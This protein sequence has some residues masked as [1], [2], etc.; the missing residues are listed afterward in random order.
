MLS[1]RTEQENQMNAYNFAVV[2][3]TGLV[4]RTFLKVLEEYKIPVKNLRLFA[5]PESKG[6]K[7]SFL[8]KE[9][10]VEE[11]KEGCFLGTDYAL[12]SAGGNVSRIWA[13]AAEKE[14]AYVIDNSSQWRMDKNCALIVPEINPEDYRGKSRIIANPNCSTIQS[15]LPLKVI[16]DLFHVKSVHYTTYQAVSGSG[17]KGIDDLERTRKGEKNQFYPYDIS[18]TCIPEIDVFFDDGYTKEEHKMIDETRKILHREDLM[19]SST[20]IRVPVKVAHGVVIEAQA[21][22]P[23]DLMKAREAFQKQKGIVLLDDPKNHIYPVSTIAEGTDKVYVGRI[24]KDLATENGILLYCVA[25]NV[26]K[27]AASNAVQIALRLIE[28]REHAESL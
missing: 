6:K 14:G 16:D 18:R 26:R 15:V 4:G 25:D 7:L 27:G 17:K 19:I 21:E 3:A 24:R 8:G 28:D 20:C 12:F 13:K 22:K 11:L 1:S 9:Y 2:G 5:S 10:E 23:I